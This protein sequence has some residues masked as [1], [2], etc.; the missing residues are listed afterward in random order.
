MGPLA[1]TLRS[2][3]DEHDA[4]SRVELR[5]RHVNA[6]APTAPLGKLRGDAP[7]GET[8]LGGAPAEELTDH[9]SACATVHTIIRWP[10]LARAAL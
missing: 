10:R 7:L 1:V 2:A 5:A 6:H 9:T 8:S 3:L 4:T